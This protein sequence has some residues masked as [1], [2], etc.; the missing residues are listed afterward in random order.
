MKQAG[1]KFGNWNP[2]KVPCVFLRQE[3]DL[4]LQRLNNPRSLVNPLYSDA[5][6]A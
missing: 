4:G 5:N 6:A 2:A 3:N 1:A